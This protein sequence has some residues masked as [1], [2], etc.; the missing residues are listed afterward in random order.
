MISEWTHAWLLLLAFAGDDDDNDDDN[1]YDSRC[2]SRRGTRTLPQGPRG[3]V[4]ICGD[5][6]TKE[7]NAS[8]ETDSGVV[9]APR[10]C[11]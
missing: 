8:L 2:S 10:R 9:S 5:E 7:T 6:K 11:D 1:N 3:D 4:L